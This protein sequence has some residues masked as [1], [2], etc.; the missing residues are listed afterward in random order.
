[1][2]D[3]NT[4]DYLYDNN[5]I[6]TIIDLI[7]SEK[8]SLSICQVQRDELDAI[9]DQIKRSEINRIPVV[10][11]PCSIGFIGPAGRWTRGFIG[12]EIGSFRLVN[13]DV[14][15]LVEPFKRRSTETHPSGNIGD[16][17]IVYTALAEYFDCLISNDIEVRTIF[18]GLHSISSETQFLDNQ[19]FGESL[20]SL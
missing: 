14:K 16:L 9:T 10:E 20:Q 4:F 1:M 2:L 11:I 8:I 5:L 17:T 6:D 15:D 7:N 19:S 13:D 12:S 18:E 3:T